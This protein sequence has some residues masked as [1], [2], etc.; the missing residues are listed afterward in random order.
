M[1]IYYSR[2]KTETVINFDERILTLNTKIKISQAFVEV[3]C[4]YVGSFSSQ[5]VSYIRFKVRH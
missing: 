5:R 1:V 3:D 2:I 4:L